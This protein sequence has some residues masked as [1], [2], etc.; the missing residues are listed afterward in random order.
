MTC[1]FAR[2]THASVS[3][4]CRNDWKQLK[5]K[6]EELDLAWRG[7]ARRCGPASIGIL[8]APDRERKKKVSDVKLNNIGGVKLIMK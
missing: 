2:I 3:P 7:T 8:R 5:R 6:N 4:L 1:D